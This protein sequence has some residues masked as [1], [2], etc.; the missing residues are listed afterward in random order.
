MS[1]WGIDLLSEY[2]MIQYTTIVNESL[3]KVWSELL[4]KID[5]PENFVPGVSDVAVLEKNSNYVIRKMTVNTPENV[6]TITEN[7][8]FSPYIVRFSIIEHPLYEGYVEN[9]AKPISEKET[10]LTFT[11]H[12]KN[13][14]TQE[15]IENPA[16]LEAAVLKTK[17]FIEN[18]NIITTD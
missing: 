18:K 6:I 13:K 11:M 8:T 14:T 17:E 5:H 16:I 9:E 2:Q 12:W 3:E 7:I 1:F 10:E 4:F 15:L